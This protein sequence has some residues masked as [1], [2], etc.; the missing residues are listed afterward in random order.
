MVDIL[1]LLVARGSCQRKLLYDA[2]Q[3]THGAL[4]GSFLADLEQTPNV[5]STPGPIVPSLNAHSD[6]FS[7]TSQRLAV[8]KE[9]FGMQGVDAYPELAGKRQLSP[10]MS[11]IAGLAEKDIKALA[12]N[13]LHVAVFA[14]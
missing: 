1:P 14:A 6:V 10:M 7:Y 9:C 8:A 3:S 12:G 13:G 5:G 4:N 2:L 11:S